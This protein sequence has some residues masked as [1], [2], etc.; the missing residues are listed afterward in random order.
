LID[1]IVAETFDRVTVVVNEEEDLCHTGF[2]YTHPA[3]PRALQPPSVVDFAKRRS[4]A[5]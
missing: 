3:S 4:L 5:V 1:I 2:R